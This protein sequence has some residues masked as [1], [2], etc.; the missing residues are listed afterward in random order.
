[1]KFLTFKN[2]FYLNLIVIQDASCSK[3][4]LYLKYRCWPKMTE[5]SPKPCKNVQIHFGVSI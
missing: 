2:V 1:M 5:L 3:R 4:N